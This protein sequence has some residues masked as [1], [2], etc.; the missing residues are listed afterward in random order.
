MQCQYW[1][2]E[3]HINDDTNLGHD[4]INDW[5]MLYYIMKQVILI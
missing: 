1:K 4:E 3:V 5:N 2:Q